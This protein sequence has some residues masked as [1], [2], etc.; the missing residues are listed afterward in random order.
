[1]LFLSNR[2]TSGAE[3]RTLEVPVAVDVEAGT[4]LYY[5]GSGSF[6][7]LEAF[8][9]PFFNP[10]INPNV[11]PTINFPAVGIGSQE[12]LKCF[13]MDGDLFVVSYI[14]TIAST[15]N[16]MLIDSKTGDFLDSISQASAGAGIAYKASGELVAGF[17]KNGTMDTNAVL[18]FFSI[19]VNTITRTLAISSSAQGATTMP[20]WAALPDGR[21]QLIRTATP[22]RLIYNPATNTVATGSREAN[23]YFGA[24]DYCIPLSNIHPSN[25]THSAWLAHDDS[26]GLAYFVLINGSSGTETEYAIGTGD[27]CSLIQISQFGYIATVAQT[28]AGLTVLYVEVEPDLL[29]ASVS[30]LYTAAI[31]SSADW[32]RSNN[33]RKIVVD[34]YTESLLFVWDGKTPANTTQNS[35][36]I[37]KVPLDFDA[38]VAFTD[39][40]VKR[41]STNFNI[42][43]S[44]PLGT[45]DDIPL[46]VEGIGTPRGLCSTGKTLHEILAGH[47]QIRYLG[48][49]TEA[50][51]EG[52]PVSILATPHLVKFVAAGAIG[53]EVANV[54]KVASRLGLFLG[55]RNSNPALQSQSIKTSTMALS[56]APVYTVQA[57]GGAVFYLSGASGKL[58]MVFEVPPSGSDKAILG[59][60]I[61]GVPTIIP[62]TPSA[63]GLTLEATFNQSV[64][65][66][67]NANATAFKFNYNIEIVQ[68][69]SYV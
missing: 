49:T 20:Y 41:I 24:G 14:D 44:N 17:Y 47:K 2:Y 35:P 29:S 16:F 28:A 45:T 13:K 4:D 31:L 53:S 12:H 69:N 10:T 51:L 27:L 62:L 25:V 6:A 55:P 56:I 1:M 48:Q 22:T 52:E 11:L 43:Y 8:D 50:A 60:H 5:D 18:T 68:E 42:Y 3:I 7:P 23:P 64:G 65:F 57:F 58:E 40:D 19:F 59:L 32:A 61:D 21:I 38:P 15:F 9:V 63:D 34:F 46:I 33:L 54:L 37:G 67:I 30:T 26:T 66:F 36:F 39:S